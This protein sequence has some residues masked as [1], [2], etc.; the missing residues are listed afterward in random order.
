MDAAASS[1]R[2]I[3]VTNDGDDGHVV[4]AGHPEHQGRLRAAMEGIRSSLDGSEWREVSARPATDAELARAHSV[5]Y[6]ELLTDDQRRGGSQLDPDTHSSP[7]SLATARLAAGACLLAVEA[8]DSGQAHHA[9]VA[10]RPPGHHALADAAMGF[11]LVNNVAV[12]AA[13]LAE[14]GERIAVID[15]DVHHGNGTQDIFYNDPRV[16]Y[17]STH[18]SPHYPGTGVLSETGGEGAERTTVNVPLRSGSSGDT[19]RAVFDQIVLERVA[20]F[21]PTRV[22]VSAGFDAHRDDPLASLGL[23][24]ADYV[25]LTERMIDVAPDGRLMVVMEGGYDLTALGRSIGSVAAVLAGAL[26]PQ[27]DGEGATSGGVDTETLQQALAA[28]R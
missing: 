24:A 21:A 5:E 17:V 7:G 4:P 25:A 13:T 2:L 15:W 6:L 11:C 20:E 10:V 26:V 3:V 18:Q 1:S 22:I 12:A 28:H 19:F 8:M 14:R 27:F 23:T 9:L 16:L